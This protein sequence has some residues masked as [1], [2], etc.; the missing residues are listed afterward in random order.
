MADNAKYVTLTDGTFQEEVL[1]ADQPVLVDFW[2]TWCGPCIKAMPKLETLARRY[3]GELEIIAV[4]LDDVAAARQLWDSRGYSMTL[5]ADDGDASRRYGVSTIPHTVLIDRA[6]VVRHVARGAAG[7]L[8][9]LIDRQ[10]QIR[11]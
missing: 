8:E 2:A 11:N 10:V 4:N 6:G 5:V 9:R 7:D 1:G 3:K